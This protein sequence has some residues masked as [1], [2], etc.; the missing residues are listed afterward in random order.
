MGTAQNMK[1]FGAGVVGDWIANNANLAPDRIATIDIA[2]TRRQTYAQMHERVGRLAGFLRSMDVA[3]GDRVAALAMNSTDLLDLMCA[4]WRLG[5]IY[6]P[7]NFRLTAKE[8]TFIVN[9][10]APDVLFGD[11]MFDEVLAELKTSTKI[12]HWVPLESSGEPTTIFE[13]E[14][15]AAQP[16]HQMIDLAPADVC[17]IMYSSGTTGLPKGVMLTHGMELFSIFN[18][19]PIMALS[20]DMVGL[21]AM[22]LFHV[23]GMNAYSIAALYLGATSIIMRAFE[24]EQMLNLIHDP[25]LA[26]TH[27]MGVPAMLNVLKD[28]PANAQTD[29]SR[30][31][32]VLTG[33]EAVPSS[34]VHWWMKR[35]VVVQEVYGMTEA[36]GATCVLPRRDVP[37]KIGSTGKALLHSPMR[38]VKSDGTQAAP[39]ELG[40]IQMKGAT[41]TPGYWNREETNRDSYVD[42]WFLSGDI[43]RMDANGYIYIEDRVKDMY[44]SGGENVYPAEVENV[45]YDLEEIAEVAVIGVPDSRWGETGCVVVVFKDNKTLS[46]ADIVRHCEGRLAKF[47]Q[48]AHMIIIDI[49]PRNATG[50]VLKF[51]LR[52]S[53]TKQLDL[54]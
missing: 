49:L 48:P 14:I 50:K 13:K 47:K 29:F 21:T 12:K 26:I 8:L 7:L 44:I 10:A 33:A 4:C 31:Q 41:I 19:A 20:R 37:E 38:I 54:K 5:A 30:I 17:M 35:G 28:H 2:S 51:E 40:E 46:L 15:A 52:Q 36:C 11:V 22:P 27:I 43:G 25:E 23:G 1:S 3:K 9:D 45:L 18:C 42:G 16:I 24:P 32:L 34:L 53:L 39:D 6:L